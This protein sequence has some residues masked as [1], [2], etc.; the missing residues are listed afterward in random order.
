MDYFG[1]FAK[2]WQPGKVKTRL[3]NSIGRQ[4]AS[5]VYCAIL[6][7]LLSSLNSTA[8]QRVIAYTP[9]DKATEFAIFPH[10]QQTPQCEG[11]LGE[12]MAHFFTQA[13]ANSAQR[14]VLIGSDCPDITSE[15]VN[16]ALEALT[17]ADVV[18]G[19]TLD[20]GYYL[21]AMAGQ[22][23]DIFSD[24]TFSTESVLEE[25]L[26]LAKRNNITVHCLDSLNDI[27]EVDDLRQYIQRLIRQQSAGEASMMES[28]L[29]E[30]LVGICGHPADSN[31]KLQSSSLKPPSTQSS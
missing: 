25:T 6:N 15:I 8:D 10:W 16:S 21:V 4:A 18:L 28:V 23:H 22:F 3:A 11:P 31:T 1:I 12:R 13:F 7:H 30:E 14:V 5:D 17:Q 27:D 29:L 9:I 26:A 20:G 2:Y 24:I 19:P